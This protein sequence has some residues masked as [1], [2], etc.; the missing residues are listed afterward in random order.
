[1]VRYI[2]H[3]KKIDINHSLM[4]FGINHLQ[5]Q[6]SLINILDI[7]VFLF[8]Y[9]SIF[10]TWQFYNKCFGRSKEFMS[11][12]NLQVENY[13]SL[14]DAEVLRSRTNSDVAMEYNS[15]GYLVLV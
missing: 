4:L 10:I 11:K 9:Y 8:L 6:N 13:M 7:I 2:V 14:V 1:M 12:S 15:I 3:E 5:L